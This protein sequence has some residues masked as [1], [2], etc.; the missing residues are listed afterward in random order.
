V[1]VKSVSLTIVLILFLSLLIFLIISLLG[2][3]PRGVNRVFITVSTDK[4]A[5]RRGDVV[6][7]TGK[8]YG[9]NSYPA[10]FTWEAKSLRGHRINFGQGITGKDG[11]FSFFFIINSVK[12]PCK[13]IIVVSYNG[14]IGSTSFYIKELT[15]ISISVS[16]HTVPVGEKVVISGSLT[17]RLRGAQIKVLQLS[18]KEE[19]IQLVEITTDSSGRFNYTWTAEKRGAYYFKA[20]WDGNDHYYGSMSNIVSVKVIEVREP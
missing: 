15:M 5:Y 3:S 13:A 20:E 1:E 12:L 19:W 2:L 4:E 6:K 11:S 10:P 18:N 7:V 14:V 17:P 16:S 9:A 8:I